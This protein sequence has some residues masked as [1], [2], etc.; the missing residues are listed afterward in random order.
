M[1]IE[2]HFLYSQANDALSTGRVMKAAVQLCF[3]TNEW[4]LMMEHIMIFTKRRS[5]LKTVSR[6]VRAQQS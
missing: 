2:E 5:Q 4:E 1:M 3:D 6:E